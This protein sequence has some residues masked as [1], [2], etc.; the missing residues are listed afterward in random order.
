VEE[1]P[2]LVSVLFGLRRLYL[3]RG[4]VQ[5]A[6]ELAEQILR[7]AQQSSDQALLLEAHI[8]L[9]AVLYYPGEFV[10]ARTHLE[11]SLTL[12]TSARRQSYTLLYGPAMLR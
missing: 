8:G 1:T 7:L 2:H 10:T 6:R 9:G 11:T 12:Y 5:R 3:H 4:Q